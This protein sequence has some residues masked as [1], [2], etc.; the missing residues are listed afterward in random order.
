[1]LEQICQNLGLQFL[2]R[3]KGNDTWKRKYS[4]MVVLGG[5]RAG[6][7]LGAGLTSQ[8]LYG[9]SHSFIHSFTY[10]FI[11]QT[12]IECILGGQALCR[13]LGIPWWTQMYSWSSCPK[14]R[15]Q[16]EGRQV[17]GRKQ[18]WTSSFQIVVGYALPCG[19]WPKAKCLKSHHLFA[20]DSAIW[21]GAG[22]GSSSCSAWH[23]LA[24]SLGGAAVASCWL[25]VQLGLLAR[26]LGFLRVGSP[27]GLVGLLPE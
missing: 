21:A 24:L 20:Q 18:T 1:M 17:M 23:R 22:G 15:L 14:G 8:N 5:N 16:E 12:S 13:V 2:L 6:W 4:T 27:W 19:K 7:R 26:G 3:T 11:Q 9:F 10:S 25:A